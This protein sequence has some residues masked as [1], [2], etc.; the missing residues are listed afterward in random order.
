MSGRTFRQ[1][2]KILEEKGVKTPGGK[3]KWSE[4]T[5]RSILRNEKYCGSAILQ[6]TFV[7][8]F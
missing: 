8:D 4:T 3:Y 5:V 2:C 6:K 1:I 7:E